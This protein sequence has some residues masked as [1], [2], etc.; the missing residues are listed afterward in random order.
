M[1]NKGFDMIFKFFPVAC[2]ILF[3]GWIL[4]FINAIIS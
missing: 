4:L 2:L 1:N 3:F